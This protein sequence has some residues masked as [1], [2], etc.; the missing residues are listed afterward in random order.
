MGAGS[1]EGKD[2]ESGGKILNLLWCK[3]IFLYFTLYP[4]INRFVE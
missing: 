1:L 4:S 3:I 2:Q